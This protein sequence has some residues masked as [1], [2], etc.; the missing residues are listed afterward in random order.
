MSQTVGAR[1]WLK[2][3]VGE[4]SVGSGLNDRAVGE[5]RDDECSGGAEGEEKFPVQYDSGPVP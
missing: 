2:H 4:Q 3:E 5:R 1:D